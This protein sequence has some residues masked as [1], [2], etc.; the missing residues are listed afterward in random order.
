MGP[1]GRFH[2][3]RIQLGSRV[4]RLLDPKKGGGSSK[5]GDQKFPL[6]TRACRQSFQFGL[7]DR[8][9]DHAAACALQISRLS[10]YDSGPKETGFLV[11]HMIGP[12]G[13]CL[14]CWDSRPSLTLNATPPIFRRVVLILSASPGLLFLREK[15]SKVR[16]ADV[17]AE[18]PRSMDGGVY[19][20]V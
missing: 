14:L 8:V 16:E 3:C 7:D 11:L 5:S 9:Y 20:S 12:L 4:A 10:Y 15:D 13:G 6:R 17:I 1:V 18:S 2:I 19:V